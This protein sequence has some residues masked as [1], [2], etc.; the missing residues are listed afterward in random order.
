MTQPA[1]ELAEALQDRYAFERE[2]GRG[3]MATVYLACDLRHDRPVAFKLLHPEL[4]ATMGPERF[5]REIRLAARLQ[6]PHILTVLDSGETSGRLWFTMPYVQGESL[7]DRLNRE[8]QLP[9]DDALRIAREAADALDYAH[10]EGIIHRDIKPENILLTGNPSRDRGATG[11]WHALVAD[12][13][14]ARALDSSG[15][16][17]LTEDGGWDAGLHEPRTG[18]RAAGAGRADRHLFPGRGALRDAGG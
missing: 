4:A 13:G 2:L 7:R 12:F 11:A 5:Q 18:E 15:S 16:H 8:V 1:A 17:A 10:H 6:H 9:I 3:G 14:I